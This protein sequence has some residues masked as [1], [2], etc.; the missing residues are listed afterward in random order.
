MSN[1]DGNESGVSASAVDSAGFD[2]MSELFIPTPIVNLVTPS[3]TSMSNNSLSA[4]TKSTIKECDVNIDDS[5]SFVEIPMK[6]DIVNYYRNV[7][8]HAK[9][10]DAIVFARQN[11]IMLLCT[12][13]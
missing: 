9:E 7:L 2:V 12:M 8:Y 4:S 1:D 11:K 13:L 10:N 5:S 6:D 3:I